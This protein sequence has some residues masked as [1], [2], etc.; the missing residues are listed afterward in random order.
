MDSKPIKTVTK[1]QLMRIAPWEEYDTSEQNIK[2]AIHAKNAE[3]AHL[4][5]SPQPVSRKNEK[6][7][8]RSMY[9]ARNLHIMIHVIY[10]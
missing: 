2:D 4:D 6:I 3:D 8:A 10:I 9:N 1:K 5:Q 7:E